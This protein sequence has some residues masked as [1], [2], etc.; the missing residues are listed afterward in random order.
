MKKNPVEKRRRLITSE[1]TIS[2][3]YNSSFHFCFC[4]QFYIPLMYAVYFAIICFVAYD[5]RKKLLRFR[6]ITF[7]KSEGESPSSLFISFHL[8]A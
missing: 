6:L 3:K 7:Y 4:F 5:G 1:R 2:Q 8:Y